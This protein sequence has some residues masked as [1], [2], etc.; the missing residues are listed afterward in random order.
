MGWLSV[1]FCNTIAGIMIL[2]AKNSDLGY[3]NAEEY[4]SISNGYE[5]VETEVE[6][7]LPTKVDCIRELLVLAFIFNAISIICLIKILY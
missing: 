1:F 3:E 5:L 2:T 4:P 7:E 6:E